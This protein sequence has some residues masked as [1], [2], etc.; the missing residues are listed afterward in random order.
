MIIEAGIR[1][2]SFSFVLPNNL[3]YSVEESHGSVRYS[4][5]AHL[6]VINEVDGNMVRNFTIC[7]KDDLNLYPDLKKQWQKED[8]GTLSALFCAPL[9][10]EVS[11][12]HSGYIPGDTINVAVKLTNKSFST[13]PKCLLEFIR[14]IK[15]TR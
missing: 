12:P 11:I 5:G 14:N 3:P 15:Y 2:F 7:R 1:T 8:K 13:V 6:I 10:L 9:L 4:V